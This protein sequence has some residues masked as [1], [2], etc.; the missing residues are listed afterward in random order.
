LFAEFWGWL[1]E[2]GAD[3]AA[4][5][6]VFRAYCYDAFAESTKLSRLAAAAGVRDAVTA[7]TG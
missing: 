7:F 6:L 3:A 2:V 1:A 4:A 5:G